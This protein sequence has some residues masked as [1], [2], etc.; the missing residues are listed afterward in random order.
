MTILIGVDI[1]TQGTK[2]ALYTETGERLAEAFEASL[3]SRPAA[4][5]A[6][7]DP[8]R[9]VGSVIRTVAACLSQP[10]APADAGCRVAAVAIDGQMA[11]VIGVDAGGRAVT[12]YDSWLDTRCAPQI[13]RMAGLAGERIV[14]RT[15]CAPSYNHGPKV[16]WWRDN[17]PELFARIVAFVQPGAY[18]AMRLC[19]LSGEHAY[20]DHTYLHFSGFADT[21]NSRWD[22]ELCRAFDVPMEKLP[23]IIAPHEVV[24]RIGDATAQQ[25]G[26]PAGVPVV[27]GCGD[28]SASFLSCGATKAGICIDVAGT[29]S[30]FAATTSEFRPDV[31]HRT[32]ACGRSAV[33]GLWHPYAYINGGGLNLEWFRRELGGGEAVLMERLDEEAASAD[34]AH[35]PLFVPH[36]AGRVSPSAPALRGAWVGLDWSHGR[37]EL[38]RAALE[39]VALEY[40]VYR[41]ALLDLYRDFQ[42][43]EVRV[44]GGGAGSRIWNRIKASVLQ[45]SVRSIRGAGG[46]PMG[47]AM[48][49][50]YGA[51]VLRDLDETA[52]RWVTTVPAGEPDEREGAAYRSRIDAYRRLL[53][54]LTRFHEEAP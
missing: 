24:G 49:A 14:A 5:A 17:H 8:E 48:L 50:G 53:E 7:E 34:P 54:L 11:G 19:G 41:D 31:A 37:A 23:R 13:E 21:P 52:Q 3:V 29:A 26:L 51:G 9:Q 42:I 1:G 27:A 16:L 46:A 38:Y 18:A 40:G 32:L 22:E 20:I 4:G 2:A 36:L 45:A 44:T 28:T 15:G 47:S 35:C 10:A 39:G 30:V 43:S 6:E 33:P 12:P 25:I